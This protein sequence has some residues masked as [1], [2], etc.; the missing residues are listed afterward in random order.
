MFQLGIIGTGGMAHWHAK[1]FSEIKD[2]KISACCDVRE[3]KAKEFG[4]KFNV[5]AVY[6][7]YQEMLEKEK[8]D[9]ISNVTNDACHAEVALAVLKKK[10]PILSEKPIATTMSDAK[11]MVTAAKKAGVVNMIN[12]SKRDSSALREAA[13]VIQDGVIG[14]IMHVEASYLQSWLASSFMGDKSNMQPGS[15]LWRLS[16]KHGSLGVLGDIGCHI[17][18]MTTFLCGDISEIHCRL[19]TFDKGVPDQKIGEYVLDAND[20]FLSSVVFKNGG[21]GVIHASRWATGQDQSLRVRVYGDKGAVEV[22]FDKSFDEYRIC[23][24]NSAHQTAWETVTCEKTPSN[25]ERFIQSVRTGKNDM[26]DF[27]A[28]MKIQAYLDCSSLS[29][30]K[31]TSVKVKL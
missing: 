26:P 31:K 6:T 22:D 2:V 29:D 17:Y 7:S 9:G 15:W 16:K 14:R 1:C 27:E 8:L 10:I 23:K 24:E 25:Y 28:G 13:K 11:K 21:I 20:S 3:E 4:A 30:E 19:K 12:F 18:D 5:P